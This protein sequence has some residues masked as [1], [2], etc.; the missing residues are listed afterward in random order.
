MSNYKLK[1]IKPLLAPFSNISFLSPALITSSCNKN[2][3]LRFKSSL[4]TISLALNQVLIKAKSEIAITEAS[5]CNYWE[6]A[7]QTAIYFQ[8]NWLNRVYFVKFLT[9]NEFIE[10]KLKAINNA[11][12][13]INLVNKCDNI[14]QSN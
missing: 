10:I 3:K 9:N 1:N 4:Q 11:N 2:S 7:N 13:P 5:N 14:N 12:V 8:D 6:S